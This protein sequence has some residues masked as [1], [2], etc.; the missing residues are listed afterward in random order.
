MQKVPGKARL[1]QKLGLGQS[2]KWNQILQ[3]TTLTS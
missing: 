3:K 2:S 1:I